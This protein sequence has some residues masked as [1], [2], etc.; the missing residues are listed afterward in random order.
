[1]KF[2]LQ[3]RA[4]NAVFKRF[5]GH[6][7]AQEMMDAHTVPPDNY[8]ERRKYTLPPAL[9]ASWRQQRRN[10][11]TGKFRDTAMVKLKSGNG[12]DGKIS[13]LR[14]S[15]RV[16]GPPDG[17]DG[18]DGGHVFIQASS[19]LS[20]LAHVR[21]TYNAAN[22]KSG[23]ST[24]LTGKRGNN[25]VLQVPVGTV[26]R[27]APTT[28]HGKFGIPETA[29]GVPGEQDGL[30]EQNKHDESGASETSDP[31]S[32]TAGEEEITEPGTTY[33][34]LVTNWSRFDSDT[35]IQLKRPTFPDGSGWHFRAQEEEKWLNNTHFKHISQRV[36]QYDLINRRSE[37]NSDMFPLHGLDMSDPNEPPRLLL[38]GGN[39]GLGN[40]HFQ[41]PELRSPTFAKKGRAGCEM[42]ILL[43]LKM[44]ADLGLVGLPNAGKST[45]LSK[46]SRATPAVGDYEFTTL[47]P[48]VGTVNLNV[49]GDKF[50]VADIPGIIK[51]AHL[52]RGLGLG[53]LR[54]I[55]RCKGVAFVIGLDRPNPLADIELLTSELGA[56]RMANKNVL[57]IANKADVEDAEGKYRELVDLAKERKWTI[58]PC[59]AKE[60]SIEGVVQAMARAAEVETS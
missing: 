34:D 49:Q 12:G 46:I 22:G 30:S 20:S 47:V 42:T 7:E 25:V 38:A 59:S 53:F 40:M 60:G 43:E 51:D 16:V 52:N 44:L 13:F 9:L 6:L 33:V 35:A 55:E 45:L 8:T 2:P 17:G 48:S 27:W 54:H 58:V 23:G 50:T 56:E 10:A 5:I 18:G 4:P 29:S 14:E 11:G 39:G 41:T 15:G 37:R 32:E 21:P 36:K 28:T 3:R 1:M 57:V 31:T 26:V 19:Q 24:Q